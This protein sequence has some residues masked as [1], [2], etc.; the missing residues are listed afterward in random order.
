MN[1]L[2]SITPE[3]LKPYIKT[4]DLRNNKGRYDDI[5]FTINKINKNTQRGGKLHR[6][7]KSK[8]KNKKNK[9]NKKGKKT[10]RKI[11]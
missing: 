8:K 4:Y 2:I 10:I 3:S 11:K 1:K 6:T 7:K 5:V 9:K